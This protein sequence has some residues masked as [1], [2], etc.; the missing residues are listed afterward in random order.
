[1]SV[2]EGFFVGVTFVIL[3][4]VTSYYFIE[5]H[6]YLRAEYKNV[7]LSLFVE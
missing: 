3:A 1:M 4:F 7:P 2:R 6:L 5:F